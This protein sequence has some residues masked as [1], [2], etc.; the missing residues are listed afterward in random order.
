MAPPNRREKE[1]RKAKMLDTRKYLDEHGSDWKPTSI[2]IP[3]GMAAFRFETPESDR[4]PTL[5]LI[6]VV[7]YPVARFKGQ[8]GGNPYVPEDDWEEGILSY[9]R[10]YFVHNNVG[11][12]QKKYTCLRKEWGEDCPI[13]EYVQELLSDPR[14]D[15]KKTVNPLREKERQMF[16]FYDRTS[17]ESR[18]KGLQVYECGHYL[19]FGQLLKDTLEAARLMDP[20]HSGL[21]FAD[22]EEGMTL[23]ITVQKTTFAGEG[24]SGTFGKPTTI[25]FVPRDRP[26]PDEVLEAAP[27]LDDLPAHMPY[28]KL[29]KLFH[30][31][32]AK[33]KEDEEGD[34]RP[35]GRSL[36]LPVALR[37]S[38]SGDDDDEDDDD[39]EER[40]AAKAIRNLAAKAMGRN[41]K[42]LQTA[43]DLGIEKGSMVEHEGDVC[44]VVYISGDGTS[45]R[46]RHPEQDELIMAVPVGDVELVDED[47]APKATP[48]RGVAKKSAP[49]TKASS[50][51]RKTVQKTDPDDEDE[52]EEDE[53]PAKKG[54]KVSPKAQAAVPEDEDDEDADD[55]EDDEE[56]LE[57]DEDEAPAAKKG[58]KGGKGG[59]PH[60][61]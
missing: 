39:D 11:P 14:V 46:L 26:L 44:E 30:Q 41:G 12:E 3:D 9:E 4:K 47:E 31:A 59:A 6:D 24:R 48:A 5:Y 58:G 25:Q 50:G 8:P 38:A 52:E 49:A 57:D 40:P 2:A 1:K 56:E 54:A 7:P 43:E 21:N 37:P 18:K 60:R 33:A 51:S 20:D 27:C 23:A 35:R 13:C 61:R 34:G 42:K 36:P 10:T 53:K 17:K 29:Y 45:L 16:L 32:D 28:D 19:S 22:P 55:D 15:R